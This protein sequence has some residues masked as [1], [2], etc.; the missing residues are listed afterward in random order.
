M[1]SLV[2]AIGVQLSAAVE[3]PLVDIE[4]KCKIV[5]NGEGE[6]SGW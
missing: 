5:R 6:L 1:V 3:T 2:P 4:M